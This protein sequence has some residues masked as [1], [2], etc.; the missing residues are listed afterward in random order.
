MKIVKN[1]QKFRKIYL[2]EIA[3]I[4]SGATPSTKNDSFWKNGSVNWLNSSEVNK[5]IILNAEN[6]ITEDGL[7]SIGNKMFPIDTIFMALAGQGKTKGMVG[8]S[9]VITSC[10]QSMGAILM[11]EN[12]NSYVYYICLKKMYKKI[13]GMVGEGREGL[14]LGILRGIELLDIKG[15]EKIATILSAQETHIN[16]IKELISKLETRNEQMAE[17]LLSGELRVREDANGDVEFY[18]NADD[19]WNEV[20]LNGKMRMIPKDWDVDLLKNIIE[21]KKGTSISSSLLNHDN[22][23][24]QYIRTNEIWD[25]SAKTKDPVFYNGALNVNKKTEKDYIIC[26]D[27]YNSNPKEGTLGMVTNN[28]IGIMSGELFK[29]G[30]IG[31][32]SK[33]FVNLYYLKSSYFQELICRYGEGSTVKHAGKHVKKIDMPKIPTNEQEI[34]N[35]FFESYE[36]EVNTLKSLVKKEK[37]IFEQLSEALLSGEY[38]IE[39]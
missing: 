3:K 39:D 35:N 27:G 37:I 38:I 31:Q 1:K 6:K 8:L 34:L 21:L 18:K 19:N 12:Y 17:R 14:N 5:G 10:N 7:K 4:S 24:E 23:G 9:K 15:Q 11:N 22:L 26:F 29:I 28:G 32:V 2:G 30:E 20:K 25:T 16:N 36:V 13:R 33:I